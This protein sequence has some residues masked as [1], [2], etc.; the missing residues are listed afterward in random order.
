[1]KSQADREKMLNAFADPE[2]S[3]TIVLSVER[4]EDDGKSFSED[5]LDDF[6]DSLFLFVGGRIC[7]FHDRANLP[8]RKLKVKIEVTVEN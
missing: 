2:G 8:A 7:A 4:K 6:R 3:D 1:M 5:A